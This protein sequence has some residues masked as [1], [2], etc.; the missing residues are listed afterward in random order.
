MAAKFLEQAPACREAAP[1]QGAPSAFVRVRKPREAG[2]VAF[3]WG[4]ADGEH[5]AR[6]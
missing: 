3:G 6:F 2:A 4:P 1:A 5:G